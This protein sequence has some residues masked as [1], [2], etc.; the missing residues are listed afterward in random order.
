MHVHIRELSTACDITRGIICNPWPVFR[1]MPFVLYY[2]MMHG[3]LPC[4]SRRE[5]LT[6][7]MDLSSWYTIRGEREGRNA[8]AIAGR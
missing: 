2:E 8:A 5:L 4:R 7:S 1:L 3:R 6:S